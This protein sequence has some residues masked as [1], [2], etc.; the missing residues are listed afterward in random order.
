M[1]RNAKAPFGSAATRWLDVDG[2]RV[3]LTRKRVKNVNLRVASPDCVKVSAP[4]SV[5]IK[6]IE[7]IVS[8]KRGWIL[9]AQDRLLHTPSAEAE[10]ASQEERDAWL[11]WTSA[12]TPALIEK[13]ERRLGVKASRVVYREMKS[14]WGSCQPVTGRICI[15]TRL[16]LYPEEC[17][18]YVVL[19]ELC[20]LLASGHGSDFKAL[21]DANM[22][23]WRIRRKALR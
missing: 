13:W 9:R 16:A 7:S 10:S 21:M 5:S 14:R 3:E 15:N 2:I 12:R 6:E 17:L 22:P 20:H 19:H 8:Q 4:R 23:D 11:A 1:S 18:D